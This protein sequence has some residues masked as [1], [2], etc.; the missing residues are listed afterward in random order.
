MST[1]CYL[2]LLSAFLHCLL[3]SSLIKI[4]LLVSQSVARFVN[5]TS[6]AVVISSVTQL[7]M[8]AAQRDAFIKGLNEEHQVLDLLLEDLKT[9]VTLDVAPT[10]QERLMLLAYLL[11]HCHCIFLSTQQ[12]RTQLRRSH[13]S[14]TLQL[15]LVQ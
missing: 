10:M 2:P 4:P 8:L 15:H 3:C 13:P 6:Y 7:F 1:V 5:S 14:Q 11:E 12:V 9:S